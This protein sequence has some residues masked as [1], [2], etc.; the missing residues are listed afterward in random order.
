MFAPIRK[1]LLLDNRSKRPG[2]KNIKTGFFEWKA[3]VNQNITERHKNVANFKSFVISDFQIPI[4][5]K[6]DSQSQ[7]KVN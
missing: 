5:F 6:F 4:L 1:S 7:E 2:G 3:S